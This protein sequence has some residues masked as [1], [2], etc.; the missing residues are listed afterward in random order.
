MRLS[1]TKMSPANILGNYAVRYEQDRYRLVLPTDPVGMISFSSNMPSLKRAAVGC[2]QTFRIGHDYCTD[3]KVIASV[4]HVLNFFLNRDPVM[5]SRG[6]TRVQFVNSKALVR[7]HYLKVHQ[8]LSHIDQV[9]LA[10]MKQAC[11]RII[12]NFAS[13]ATKPQ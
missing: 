6:L 12:E 5:A 9:R 4:R 2:C 11:T 10:R 1:E 3:S 13:L 7:Y 8:A